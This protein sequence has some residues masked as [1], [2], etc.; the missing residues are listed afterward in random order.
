M[1][2]ATKAAHLPASER[3]P[4]DTPFFPKAFIIRN[5]PEL[6][7]VLLSAPTEPLRLVDTP[8]FDYGTVLRDCLFVLSD[9]PDSATLKES[10]EQFIGDRI[11][12]CT[13]VDLLPEPPTSN[14]LAS[15]SLPVLGRLSS[16]S[17]FASAPVVA[18]EPMIASS[19][20]PN[21]Q[22]QLRVRQERA[23][24]RGRGMVGQRVRKQFQKWGERWYTGRITVYKP[25][26]Q[27]G[28]SG[29]LFGVVYDED[30]GYEEYSLTDLNRL[31]AN[32]KD[33]SSSA[34]ATAASAPAAHGEAPGERGAATRRRKRKRPATRRAPSPETNASDEAS[35]GEALP[36][37][38]GAAGGAAVA[39]RCRECR[40]GRRCRL[41]GR[42]GHLS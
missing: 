18:Q 8:P 6:A 20:A 37:R 26:S 10:W 33:A 1:A 25:P 31:L 38:D 29:G 23:D 14:T 9:H 40:A 22:A 7:T 13:R 2:V 24:E 15:A 12:N 16:S 30:D 19:L 39:S 21:P 36:G 32:D 35:E 34:A 42:P 5:S 4:E 41:A 3:P 27:I 11:R 28:R 17:I